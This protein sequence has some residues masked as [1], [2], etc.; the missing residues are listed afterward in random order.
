VTLVFIDTKI[1]PLSNKNEVK[2]RHSNKPSILQCIV[3]RGGTLQQ[4]IQLDHNYKPKKNTYIQT[5]F[6]RWL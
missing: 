4:V 3:A 1:L 6:N 5:I 2:N